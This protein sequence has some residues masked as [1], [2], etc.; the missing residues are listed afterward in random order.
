MVPNVSSV[1]GFIIIPTH[2][3]ESYADLPHLYSFGT[4]IV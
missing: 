4:R 3:L 2:G 1:Y